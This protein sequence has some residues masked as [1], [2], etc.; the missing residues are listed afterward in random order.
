MHPAR[1]PV[2]PVHISKIL[3]F[4]VLL[5][6]ALWLWCAS[7]ADVLRGGAARCTDGRGAWAQPR[8]R[9]DDQQS[10][11][12]WEPGWEASVAEQE[13]LPYTVLDEMQPGGKTT[14]T[15]DEAAWLDTEL[16]ATFGGHPDFTEANWDEMRDIVRRCSYCFANKPQ[17]IK[18]YHG[19]A[20]HA[21]F[22]IPFE[23]ESKASYQRP[24]RY[25]PGEQEI[26]DIHCKELLEY[27]FIE[28]ASNE[29]LQT[30]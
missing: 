7:G 8:S 17:D 20:E 14:V 10:S 16:N 22:S 13:V 9:W 1:S 29:A 23:D 25:S 2:S 21:T 11:R 5:L 27:G 4:A 12:Q 26:I 30:C 19:N 18:G 15:K 24:R 28:P 6:C 3:R